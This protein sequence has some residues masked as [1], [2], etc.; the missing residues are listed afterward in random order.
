MGVGVAV[1]VVAA[2]VA[3]ALGCKVVEIPF[4]LGDTSAEGLV[5]TEKRVVQ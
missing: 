5:D 1:V 4:E 3:Q 2:A